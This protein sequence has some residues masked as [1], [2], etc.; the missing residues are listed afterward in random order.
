MNA[1]HLRTTGF[2]CGA[3]PQ[4]VEK[5]LAPIPGV[6]QVA[7]VRSMGLTSILFDPAVADA[8]DLCARIR[9]AGF[10]AEVYSVEDEQGDLEEP[11]SQ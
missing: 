11:L 10:G 9:R 4:V 6:M 2:Y 3:C 1:L 8:E 5:A 7:I